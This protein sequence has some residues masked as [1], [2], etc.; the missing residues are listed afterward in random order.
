MPM[1][2][3]AP[4]SDLALKVMS[5]LQTSVRPI[6]V[7]STSKLR[8]YGNCY[9]NVEAV[10]AERGGSMVLGWMLYQEPNFFLCAEH[11]AIWR[12]PNGEL[13]DVTAKSIP[14]ETSFI[15]SGDEALDL[16]RAPNVRTRYVRLDPDP[17]LGEFLAAYADFYEAETARANWLHEMG[18]RCESQRGLA[19]GLERPW[20]ATLTDEQSR[21]Y[22]T[23][24]ANCQAR[25]GAMAAC[26]S[27]C[28]I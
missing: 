21:G 15:I 1:Q 22:A 5:E 19:R 28:R 9:W 13:R 3:I 7:Q 17:A 14:M 25:L 20:N 10:A 27:R 16:G 12:M 4:N 8:P 6:R 23:L 26:R 2:W 24:V 18:Y 11:H